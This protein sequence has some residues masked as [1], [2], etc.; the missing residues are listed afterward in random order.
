MK[1]QTA[2]MP[3]TI[4]AE[5][6]H[7]NLGELMIYGIIEDFESWYDEDSVTPKAVDTALKDMGEV[8]TLNIRINSYGGS[9]FAGNAILTMLNRFPADKNVYIEGLCASMASVIACGVNG[10]VYMSDNSLMMTH[11]A[12]SLAIGNAKDLREGADLLDKVDGIIRGIYAKRFKGAPEEL[13]A[14]LNYDTDKWIAADEALEMGLIDEIEKT[15]PVAACMET[16]F[17][18]GGKLSAVAKSDDIFK[19]LAKGG[20]P[21]MQ[22][23]NENTAGGTPA[24]ENTV[25]NATQEAQGDA[26]VSAVITDAIVSDQGEQAHAGKPATKPVSNTP[27]PNNT[28]IIHGWIRDQFGDDATADSIAGLVEYGK[29]YRDTLVNDAVKAGVQAQGNDF[30][31][32]TMQIAFAKMTPDEIKAITQS[33]RKSAEAAL[34]TGRKSA[35][36]DEN[37][38]ANENVD[39]YRI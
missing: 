19:I 2:Q 15:I 27:F 17:S 24:A 14:L 1:N 34:P 11:P 13:D 29:D 4:R 16:L 22:K 3:F 18:N 31:A 35:V 37:A 20:K 10:K 30:P 28:D 6:K 32:E 25:E 21:I 36:S 8:S 38:A 12:S 5:K 9:C 7:D 39:A 26:G 23:D 33:Y